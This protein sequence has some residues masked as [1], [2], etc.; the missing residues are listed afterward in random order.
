MP[1][2][3]QLVEPGAERADAATECLLGLL[4]PCAGL[5]RLG[6]D[7]LLQLG[8]PAVETGLDTRAPLLLTCSRLQLLQLRPQ[9]GE[10]A[11]LGG[12]P[13]VEVRGT[14]L[15]VVAQRLRPLVELTRERAELVAQ[16]GVGE[17][18]VVIGE[19]LLQVLDG[20]TFG[21]ARQALGQRLLAFGAPAPDRLEL[22]RN[23]GCVLGNASVHAGESVRGLP[24]CCFLYGVHASV[25]IPGETGDLGAQAAG[26][27]V[28]CSRAGVRVEVDLEC[29][30]PLL[31]GVERVDV[32]H[33]FV[34]AVLELARADGEGLLQMGL[35]PPLHPFERRQGALD[36]RQPLRNG[37]RPVGVCGLE[38]RDRV[39]QLLV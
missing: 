9:R 27:L 33:R 14:T 38:L 21:E 8:N 24:A 34:E 28:E 37:V 31:Q 10:L 35:Q 39:P 23:R 3:Q 17:L 36:A 20:A 26:D 6:R 29:R 25:E 19:P 2:P 22:R 12:E 4:Q 13:L 1:E 15:E 7:T 32:L 16:P 30:E 5:R 11:G 18:P